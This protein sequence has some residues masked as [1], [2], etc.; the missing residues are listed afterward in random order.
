MT[1][2]VLELCIVKMKIHIIITKCTDLLPCDCVLRS[3]LLA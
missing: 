3:V 1:L 2:S